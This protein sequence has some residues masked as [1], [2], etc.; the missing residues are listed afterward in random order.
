MVSFLKR[1]NY[2]NPI[3][4]VIASFKF[5]SRFPLYFLINLFLYNWINLLFEIISSMLWLKSYIGPKQNRYC[6]N[7]LYVTFKS[8]E[9]LFNLPMVVYFQVFIKIFRCEFY[10]FSTPIPVEQ[11]LEYLMV[12]SDEISLTLIFGNMPYS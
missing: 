10:L 4:T 3:L 12:K 6:K 8:K 5:F 2:L 9:L 1:L 7:I 11:I